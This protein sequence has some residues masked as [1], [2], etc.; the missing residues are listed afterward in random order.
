MPGEDNNSELLPSRLRQVGDTVFT[1]SM[2]DAAKLV[3]SAI[4][5][6]QLQSAIAEV[7]AMPNL[8]PVE[9]A[10]ILFDRR[11]GDT[12]IARREIAA[13]LSLLERLKARRYF[14][15]VFRMLPNAEDGVVDISVKRLADTFRDAATRFSVER[16]INADGGSAAAPGQRSY[17]LPREEH[18]AKGSECARLWSDQ[19][20]KGEDQEASPHQPD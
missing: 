8:L 2:I 17:S 11:A 15:P 3:L 19:R 4:D 13:G 10:L 20:W 18:R 16:E 9:L 1:E 6:P 5:K 12:A 14:R 7:K